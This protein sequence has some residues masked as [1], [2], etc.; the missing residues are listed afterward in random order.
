MPKSEKHWEVLLVEDN[1]ADVTLFKMAFP[2]DRQVHV[3]CMVDG[4]Q[5]LDYLYRRGGHAEAARPDLIFLDLN[6]PVTDGREVLQI[7]KENDE[8]KGIPIIVL[9]TSGTKSDIA[10]SYKRGANSY[11]VKPADV[12]ALFTMINSCCE[13]WFQTVVLDS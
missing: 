3:S 2:K 8:L 5:A 13:Y 12:S 9:S 11:M 6:L 4:S 7:V 1:P 10:D